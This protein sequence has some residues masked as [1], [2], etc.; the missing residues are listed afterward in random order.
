MNGLAT[1]PSAQARR[2]H[3]ILLVDDSP[4]FTELLKSR[5]LLKSNPSWI[6]HTANNYSVALSCLQSN[7]VDLVVSDIGMPVVD[8]LQ[9]LTMVKRN[10]PTLPVVMLSGMVTPERRNYALEQGAALVLDKIDI[11]SDFDS[12]YP[13]LEATVEA[14]AEGFKGMVRQVGLTEVLQLECLGRKSSVLEIVSANSKGSIYISEGSIIHAEA[15]DFVGIKALA[16]LLGL[17]GGEFKLKPFTQPAQ[18]S[19]E[20][21]WE[22]LLM[23]AAQASDEQAGELAKQEKAGTA[24]SEAEAASQ[25]GSD[26][27]VEE[28]VLSSP[29]NEVLYRW[30]APEAEKRVVLLDW[31]AGKS[32]NACQIFPSLGRPDRMEVS[33]TRSRV[34]CLFQKD[35]KT[36]VRVAITS[37]ET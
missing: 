33:E 16:R 14:P 12:I 8:G 31:L 36:F 27:R 23:E 35:H 2:S 22:G 28:V 25:I 15:G 3:R 37:P 5:L 17:K 6:V 30:N 20:G 7:P 11:G 13:A 4:D 26:R 32:A 1:P 34:I 19:V 10:H 9:L 18:Q 29:T 24:V 21:Q